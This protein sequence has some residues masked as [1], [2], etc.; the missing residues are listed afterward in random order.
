MSSYTTTL[1][2]VMKDLNNRQPKPIPEMIETARPKI[3]DFD[4]QTPPSVDKELFKQ[5]F[6]TTFLSRFALWEI[7]FDTFEQFHLQL[8]SKCSRIMPMYSILFERMITLQQVGDSGFYSIK[9]GTEKIDDKEKLNRNNN[10]THKNIHSTL[11]VNM[12]DTGTIGGTQY[13]DDGTK[14]ET[15]NNIIDNNTKYTTKTYNLKY[16]NYIDSLSKFMEI[17]MNGELINISNKLFDE[18]NYLFLG[19][20]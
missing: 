9:K 20:M 8:W 15:S 6:E 18:F 5:W 17:I 19:V 1:N 16:G 13:A 14:D 7:T 3:F 4:Y 12:I 11:P 2:E 10:T